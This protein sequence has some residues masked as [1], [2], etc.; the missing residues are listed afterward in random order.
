[1]HNLTAIVVMAIFTYL[2]RVSPMILIRKPINSLFI[3]SFLHYIPYAILAAMTVPYIF[4]ATGHWESALIGTL[5]AVLLAWQKRSLIT[6]SLIAVLFAYGAELL[7]I[8][9]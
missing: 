3:R 9:L 6:V 2:V 8:T 7:I 4:Y 1:M 5:V